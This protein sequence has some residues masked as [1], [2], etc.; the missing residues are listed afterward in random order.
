MA[1][2]ECDWC[3][4]IIKDVIEDHPDWPKKR[5]AQEVIKEVW[6]IGGEVGCENK[7]CIPLRRAAR[8]YYGE[9]GEKNG[10]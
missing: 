3:K 9:R 2:F 5:Q 4:V 7:V 6:E 1:R 10:H 8:I